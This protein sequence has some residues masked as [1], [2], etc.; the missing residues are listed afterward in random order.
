LLIVFKRGSN[1]IER[2]KKTKIL[3][4]IN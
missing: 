4:D 2:K 3:K 1:L